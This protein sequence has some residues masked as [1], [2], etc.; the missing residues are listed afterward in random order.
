MRLHFWDFQIHQITCCGTW[1]QRWLN[2]SRWILVKAFIK[3][4]LAF[5]IDFPLECMASLKLAVCCA[6]H[7]GKAIKLRSFLLL[8]NLRLTNTSSFL[9]PINMTQTSSL[10][11]RSI[12]SLQRWLEWTPVFR[13]STRAD[14]ENVNQSCW[15]AQGLFQASHIKVL[16]QHGAKGQSPRGTWKWQCSAKG[17][18]ESNPREQTWSG[19]YQNY[20]L[21]VGRW[22]WS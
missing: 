10:L 20:H 11:Y 4:W 13:R 17:L 7:C 22:G 1:Q 6:E 2:L 8:Q 19:V 16:L 21:H 15:M 3:P 5:A 12:F 9:V 18:E 14:C